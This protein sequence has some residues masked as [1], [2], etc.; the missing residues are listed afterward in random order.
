MNREQWDPE[1]KVSLKSESEEEED[2]QAVEEAQ[3]E[4]KQYE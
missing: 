2:E 3:E 1:K 4:V